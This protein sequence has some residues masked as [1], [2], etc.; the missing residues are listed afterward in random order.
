M[1]RKNLDF[2]TWLMDN[3]VPGKIKTLHL[4]I[5][6]RCNNNCVFC[7]EGNDS[8]NL[9]RYKESFKNIKEKL[10]DSRDEYEMVSFIGA[11]PTLRDDFIEILKLT[12]TLGFKNYCF[13]TN[14]RQFKDYEFAKAVALSGVNAVAISLAGGTAETHDKET[15][16]PGS[17]NDLVAGLK[18]IVPFHND[19][20]NV[21]VNFTMNR[22]N[23]RD[24]D[25]VLDLIEETGVKEINIRNTMP[26]SLRT[27]GSKEV[28]MKMSEISEYI[29][30]TLKRREMIS[31]KS[32]PLYFYLQDFLP[33]TL[34]PEARDYAYLNRADGHEYIR[35]PLCNDCKYKE[36][37]GI[38]KEYA[39]IYGTEE[40]R[41]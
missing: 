5:G 13:A 16:S 8:R 17:F 15:R 10:E 22:G 32:F 14:G 9:L 3:I 7:Y 31:K 34:I 23:Y 25:L 6:Y 20:F 40:F 27:I 36:C 4:D 24:L 1:E 35:I 41:L 39:D 19:A 21:S 2:D 30:S 11:E 33:C 38:L 18:N 26:L 28:I 29:G 37:S 12:K